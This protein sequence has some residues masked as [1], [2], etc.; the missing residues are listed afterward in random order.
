MVTMSQIVVGVDIAKLKFDV[1]SLNNAKY[2]HNLY[3]Q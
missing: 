3:E 2:K 1:A